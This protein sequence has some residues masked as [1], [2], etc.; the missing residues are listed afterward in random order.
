MKGT[1]LEQV[2]RLANEVKMSMQ[3]AKRQDDWILVSPRQVSPVEVLGGFTNV[4][5]LG[6]RRF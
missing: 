2:W 3:M 5:E 4:N 6:C 1:S